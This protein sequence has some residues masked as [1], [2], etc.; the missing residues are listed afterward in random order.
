MVSLN[1]ISAVHYDSF[2]MLFGSLISFYFSISLFKQKRAR[3]EAKEK[4]N[5]MFR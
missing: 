5:E 3:R 2:D 1:F 4:E